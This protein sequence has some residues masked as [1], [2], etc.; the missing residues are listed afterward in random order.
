MSNG[1]NPMDN[2]LLGKI[3]NKAGDT[4]TAKIVDANRSATGQ[5]AKESQASG[6]TVELTSSAKLLERLEKTL[7]GLPEV[8]RA[9]VD[10]VK[11]QIENG[12]YE[13]DASKISEAMMRLDQEIGRRQ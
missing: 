4:G 10:A 3:S 11:A 13:I 9:Q 2:G 6:D 1:I 7:S 8:D 12:E 5:G